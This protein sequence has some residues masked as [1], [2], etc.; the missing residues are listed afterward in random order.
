V[1]AL[2]THRLS[3]RTQ[4]LAG[5]GV[6]VVLLLL[7][8]GLA[9]SRLS[10]EDAHVSTLATRVVPATNLVGEM[11]ATM[12]KY[13][14]DQ[15]HYILSTPAERRGAAGVSGDLAGDLTLMHQ[16][17]GEYRSR[18]L[19]A[20][21][22]DARLMRT[23]GSQFFSYVARTASFRHLADT[24]A[25]ATASA[26]VGSG[27]GDAEYTT[28]KGTETSWES[29]KATIATRSARSARASYDGGR[30]LILLILGLAVLIAAGLAMFLSGRLSRG[31]RAVGSAATAIAHGEVDQHVV[32]R[33]HDE[34]GDMAADF[35]EMIAYL[36]EKAE[37]ATA[38]AE[39]DLSVEIPVRS[40][41][42]A[43]GLALSRMT[44]GLRDLVGSIGAATGSMNSSSREIARNSENTGRTVDEVSS[45]IESV[46]RGSE[47]QARSIE[48]AR[49]VAERLAAAAD[50]G[51]RI[52]RATAGAAEHASATAGEGAEAV[53][54]AAEA[55]A[56]VRTASES[57]TAA[58][59]RLGHKS[60][61]IG[62]I[63]Q[64]ITSIAEQ[65]NLL[66]LNAAIE[67]A[68]AG[69]TGKGFAVV[70]EEVRK[71]A[72]ESQEAASTISGLIAEIQ[73]ETA[74]TVDIV[75]Q[76]T[77]RSTQSGEVVEEARLAFH[78]LRDSVGEMSSRVG[79]IA[80]VVDEIAEGAQLVH[81]QMVG[82]RRAG[83]RLRAGDGRLR[84][85]VRGVGGRP[86]R[87]RRPPRGARRSLSPQRRGPGGRRGIASRLARRGRVQCPRASA[88]SNI[89]CT[90]GT[91]LT[92]PKRASQ[93]AHRSSSGMSKDPKRC[94][95]PV[96]A[97]ISPGSSAETSAGSRPPTSRSSVRA[98]PAGCAIAHR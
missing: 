12:N 33:S 40:E 35:N 96:N 15:L 78:A 62:G 76:G 92:I 34:L 17:L 95:G 30:L 46:A 55:M 45:A 97:R 61:E 52:A 6:L 4:L 88:V 22:H 72:E 94:S 26:V 51:T 43:L 58:I 93:R 69:E 54:R 27:P 65:T 47:E 11:A 77:D 90:S 87:R 57:A 49:A 83:V 20:D 70:A 68:R 91:R 1:S 5:F 8:G 32:V 14:K 64:T 13:R 18:G 39:G 37:A 59:T 74:S 75:Q 44:D 48:E 79:E 82:G 9:I 41:R 2:S 71:L 73:A 80:G 24:G 28:L 16:L 53:Q 67:A 7:V 29:Y 3:I 38:I 56:E 85:G 25:T 23:F 10:N 81:A 21:A 86:Q 19:V 36:S 89:V 50:S 42:D 63:T 98:A 84:P 31:I 60:E 66:A